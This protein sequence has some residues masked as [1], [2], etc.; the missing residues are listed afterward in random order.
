MVLGGP[1]NIW[2]F[3]AFF[4]RFLALRAPSRAHKGPQWLSMD[5]LVCHRKFTMGKLGVS[6]TKHD[7]INI[8]WFDAYFSRFQALKGPQM[9][10]QG[11]QWFPMDNL[12]CHEKSRWIIFLW[13][14]LTMRKLGFTCMNGG[15]RNIWWF[16]A[17]FGRF[18]TLRAPQAPWRFPNGQPS[19]P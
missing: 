2:W 13:D 11:P 3:E 6:Q 18:Q 17:C 10:P 9:A 1:K 7:Q 12:V 4:I 19:V 8:G 15:Q 5:N 14:D 16:V